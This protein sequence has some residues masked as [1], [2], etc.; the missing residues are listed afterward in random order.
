MPDHLADIRLQLGPF[1]GITDVYFRQVF[2]AHFTG[3][4]KFFTPFLS[5]IHTEN[6]RNLRTDELNP[7]LNPVDQLTP[8][9]LSNDAG[10]LLRFARQCRAMGYKEVNLNMGC[11]Y[12][13]VAKKKRGSG[14]LP[15]AEMVDA[16][17][18]NYTTEKPLPISIK[19]RLGYN[20]S[21]EIDRLLPIFNRMHLSELII[22]AR[23]GKQMY[24]GIPDSGKFA[25]LVAD[26]Q[27][28]VVYNGDIFSVDGFANYRRQF[29]GVHGW[30]LGR[31]LLADP[32]LA[33]D[34]KQLCHASNEERKTKVE[35]F[36]TDLYLRRRKARADNPAVLGRMKE[37]WSYLHHSFSQP[38]IAWRLIR[39][40]NDFESYESAVS[41]IFRHQDWLGA[42]YQRYT[43][44]L[45]SN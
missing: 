29:P 30:M 40:S 28:P 23:L 39:R 21:D 32:F 9:L 26:I 10:E 3:I 11:P 19:C 37:L 18:E 12:P 1:Q 6:S 24:S 34:I 31:G 16:M 44:E 13:Q 41:S 36:I 20:T 2:M 43:D 7:G 4:D 33:A 35:H 25:A 5:G 8:Q 38:A 45:K 27:A 17:A 14:L 15:F 22:H 42:G